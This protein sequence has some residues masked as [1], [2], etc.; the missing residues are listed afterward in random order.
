MKAEKIN[1]YIEYGTTK[2][3]VL[4]KEKRFKSEGYT[5]KYMLEKNDSDSL[6]VVLSGIPR[7]GLK[8]RYNYG[9]TLSKIKANKLFILDDFGYDQ[10]GAW[11]LGKNKD[12][13]IKEATHKLIKKVKKDLN[14]ENTIYCGSSKGG[15]NALMFG[16]EDKGSTI[17]AGGP[18][19]YLGERLTNGVY[20]TY[21]LP[22]IMGENYNDEDI[23][24]LNDLLPNIVKKSKENDCKIFLHYSDQEYMYDTHVRYLVKD[25]H[26]NEINFVEDVHKYKKHAE[27]A[28]HF[29][30][31]LVKSLNKILS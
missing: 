5:I 8:A 19:Y 23:Q 26:D 28:Y 21:T 12:F 16:L 20:P 14:I 2:L 3:K 22:Y 6:I 27:I 25:L 29:P 24:V 31:F 7:Q 17:I 18:Q 9:R 1:K 15:Y 30:K 11:Y 13:K 10:R 4:Y